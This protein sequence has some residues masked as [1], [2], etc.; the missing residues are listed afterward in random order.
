MDPHD[1]I[2]AQFARFSAAVE[3]GDSAAFLALCVDDAPPQIELFEE[4]SQKVKEQGWKL[5]IRRIDQEGDIAEVGF[6]VVGPAG[7]EV[8][9]GMVTFSLEHDGWR[10]RSL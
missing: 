9:E 4:N 5:R 6:Q 1:E 10:L 2:A 8:D 3:E 7:D